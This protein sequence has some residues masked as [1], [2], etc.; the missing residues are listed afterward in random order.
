MTEQPTRICILGGGFGGLYTALRLTQLPWLPTQTPEITIVDSRDRFVFAPLLYELVTGELQAWEIAPPFEQL[1]EETPIRFIQGTVADIDITAQQVQL[2][3]GQFLDYDRL[4]LAMGGETPLDI[5]P[6]S[7]QYAIPFRR[8]E[9]AY[10]L[11]ERLRILEASDAEKIRVAIIGGGYSGVEL[12]CKLA[13]R[14]GKR[15]R[16]RL[17]ERGEKIL[18]SAPDFNRE[19]AQKALSERQVWLDLETTVQSLDAESIT[20]EYRDQVDTLPVDIVM[21]TV[22]TQTPDLV[23]SL[24]LKQN[25]EHQ[26]IIN[27]QL[28]VIEHPEIFALGDLADCHDAE[29]KKVPK[30]AQAAFQ[31]ADYA[32]WNLWASL[33]GRPLLSFHYQALGEMMTL[34]KDN[35]TLTGLGIKL[36]GQLAHVARRL[37]Y[38]YRLP[39]LEHQMRVAFNWISRPIQELMINK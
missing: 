6:G 38:L 18:K 13:E 36:D 29:G 20:L 30:T 24:P 21:W 7:Q 35:A 23:R 1:L 27:P 19:A 14:L 25:T 26:I 31:Q 22:G 8:V 9:D 11:Q 3:D 12:A 5:V 16:L 4:V 33:T 15:G 37:I 2:Q 39:T 28:Q 32:G 34:G 10:R 17:V